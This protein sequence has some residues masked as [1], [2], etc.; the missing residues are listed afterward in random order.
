MTDHHDP[1][2]RELQKQRQL[3]EWKARKKEEAEQRERE[4]KQAE[5]ESY[6]TR[7][8]REWQDTTGTTPPADALA[9]WQQEYMGQKEEEYQRKR[10][11]KLREV[12]AELGF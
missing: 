10:A 1:Y 7:R 3:G 11:E 9:Q 12:E 2:Q 6:L 5:L 4:A 8:G